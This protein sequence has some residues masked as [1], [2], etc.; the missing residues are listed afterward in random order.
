[1]NPPIT[2]GAIRFCPLRDF[3]NVI[4]VECKF[5]NLEIQQM[6]PTAKVLPAAELFPEA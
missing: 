2:P 5:R 6:K 1:M 3:W 4:Q